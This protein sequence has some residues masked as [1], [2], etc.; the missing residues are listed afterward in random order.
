M[1]AFCASEI[2]SNKSRLIIQSIP[3][4]P[5]FAHCRVKTNCYAIGVRW[6]SGGGWHTVRIFTSEFAFTGFRYIFRA[7]STGVVFCRGSKQAVLNLHQICMKV[8]FPFCNRVGRPNRSYFYCTWGFRRSMASALVP[9]KRD[10]V[11]LVSG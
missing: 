6:R 11:Y 1:D 9:Q 2:S 5:R 4:K 8:R 7:I 10:M 3:M